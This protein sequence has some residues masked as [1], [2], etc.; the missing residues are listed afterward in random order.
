MLAFVIWSRGLNR[1]SSYVRP[2]D[3]HWPGSESAAVMRAPV[4]AAGVAGAELFF[5]LAVEHPASARHTASETIP[6][7]RVILRLREVAF[8]ARISEKAG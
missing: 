1:C 5:S 7:Q 2:W 4:T 8:G 6:G 3:I